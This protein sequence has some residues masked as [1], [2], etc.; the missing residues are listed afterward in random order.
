MT[1][2]TVEK[3]KAR[4]GIVDYRT[5][6]SHTIDDVFVEPDTMIDF[7]LKQVESQKEALKDELF[8]G[9]EIKIRETVTR[10]AEI[11]DELLL[12]GRC[13]E[14]RYYKANVASAIRTEFQLPKEDV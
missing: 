10:C 2:L 4:I 7:L 12:F 14:T 8:N 11:A 3:I 6:I 1:Q 9:A 13:N 5:H